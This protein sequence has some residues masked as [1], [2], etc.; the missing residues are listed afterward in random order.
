MDNGFS[1]FLLFKLSFR[2][3]LLSHCYLFV[4]NLTKLSSLFQFLFMHSYIHTCTWVHTFLFILYYILYFVSFLIPLRFLLIFVSLRCWLLAVGEQMQKYLYLH[5]CR[6]AYFW[7]PKGIKEFVKK[8]IWNY[9]YAFFKLK[10]T[11]LIV[12]TI[13]SVFTYIHI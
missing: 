7:L 8:K 13:S 2:L 9:A 1:F 4:I 12:R 6:Y 10:Y 11:L 5:M 3:I